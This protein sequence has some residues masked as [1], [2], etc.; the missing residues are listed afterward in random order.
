MAIDDQPFKV[1]GESE[2]ANWL[3]PQV[4]SLRGPAIADMVEKRREGMA[5]ALP[6]LSTLELR[7]WFRRR[8]ILLRAFDWDQR[9]VDY[10]PLKAVHACAV[11]QLDPPQPDDTLP[12]RV[13]YPE[14]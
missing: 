11:E 12:G 13:P 9:W 10:A 6:R 2:C 1:N 7:A 14:E 8:G 5:L 3:Y 4:P